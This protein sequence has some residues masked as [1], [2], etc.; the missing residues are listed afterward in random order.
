VLRLI[1]R[2]AWGR[3]Y[4]I[5]LLATVIRFR[6]EPCNS[7]RAHVID[8]SH[9]VQVVLSLA[10]YVTSPHLIRHPMFDPLQWF[11][12]HCFW[13]WRQANMWQ[14][15]SYTYLP[16]QKVKVKGSRNRPSVAQRL[17]GIP[18]FPWHSAHEGGEVVSPTDRPP[19]LPGNVPGTHFH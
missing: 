16:K 12:G 1:W 19:S 5:K 9:T 14:W 15:R 3:K 10:S 17:P 7:S 6:L 8:R 2:R 4:L 18:R 13:C 11:N